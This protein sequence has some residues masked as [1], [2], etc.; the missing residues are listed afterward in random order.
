MN[1]NPWWHPADTDNVGWNRPL[2]A[3]VRLA[4]DYGAELPLWGQGFGNIAWQFTRFS[5]ELLDRLAAWQEEFDKHFLW[6]RGWSSTQEKERWASEGKDLASQV[7]AELGD[8]A[9]LVLD[10]WPCS[11]RK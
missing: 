6:D 8:R 3:V 10:L 7:R 1:H 2:P 9:E 5:P 11:G 4:P